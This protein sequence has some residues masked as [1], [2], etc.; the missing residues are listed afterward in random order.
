MSANCIECG[1]RLTDDEKRYYGNSCGDCERAWQNRIQAWR[2][3]GDDPELDAAFDKKET[4][5]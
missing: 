2:D 1:I 5:Q 3:G 4:R